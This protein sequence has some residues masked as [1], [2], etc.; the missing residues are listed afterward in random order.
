MMILILSKLFCP[1]PSVFEQGSNHVSNNTQNGYG[2]LVL[3]T[4]HVNKYSSSDFM[5][6]VVDYVYS[7]ISSY[8]PTKLRKFIDIK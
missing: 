2:I 6:G 4:K 5:L 3:Q 1:F 8:S 7:N